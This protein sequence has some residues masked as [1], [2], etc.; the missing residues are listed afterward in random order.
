MWDV[1]AWSTHAACSIGAIER[2][3]CTMAEGSILFAKLGMHIGF[4]ISG[5][6]ISDMLADGL[7]LMQH[8]AACSFHLTCEMRQGT[9]MHSREDPALGLFHWSASQAKF[10]GGQ[11]WDN[12]LSDIR[13]GRQS[14]RTSAVIAAAD[15]LYRRQGFKVWRLDRRLPS[16]MPTRMLEVLPQAAAMAGCTSRSLR[17]LR[18]PRHA[19]SEEGK[20][21]GGG[22]DGHGLLQSSPHACACLRRGIW[23]NGNGVANADIEIFVHILEA[24]PTPTRTRPRRIFVVGN[25]WGYSSI[26]LGLLFARKGLG[27]V[28]VID[29]EVEDN[30]TTVGSSLTRSLA[31]HSGL[32]VQLTA[33]FS[34][35]DVTS[36]M[37]FQTYDVAFIDGLHT[38]EALAADWAAVEP[39]LARDSPVAVVLHDVGV[40]ALHE[41][42]HKIS[43]GWSHAMPLGWAHKNLLGTTVLHRGFPAGAFRDLEVER[44]AMLHSGK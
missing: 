11:P 26:I 41:T 16:L 39:H 20:W 40:A 25:S 21:H 12:L 31:N 14:R 6:R 23:P 8:M 13:T 17:E 28:D 24:M 29:A 43:S 7:R 44:R 33:G 10:L 34:P 35:Q 2:P 38:N 15:A 5:G 32:D 27:S 4:C 9:R 30:C 22:K 37:R 19:L 36:A 1:V 18:Q 3:P 42:V